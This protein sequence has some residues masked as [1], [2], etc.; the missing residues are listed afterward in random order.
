MTCS[1]QVLD[2]RCLTLCVKNDLLVYLSTLA[3]HVAE[4]MMRLIF[5]NDLDV[6]R[7]PFS[8]AIHDHIELAIQVAVSHKVRP[9]DVGEPD[10]CGSYHIS[11]AMH[12]LEEDELASWFEQLE[13]RIDC[14]SH[15]GRIDAAETLDSHNAIED[16]LFWKETLTWP[17]LEE[18]GID[19]GWNQ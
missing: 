7:G 13:D 18:S 19:E 4:W 2:S 3:V 9:D 12:V 15:F 14:A 10:T 1:L 17:V 16:A 11:I 6:L 8:H 5:T